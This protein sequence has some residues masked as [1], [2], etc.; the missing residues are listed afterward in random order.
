MKTIMM[1]AIAAATLTTACASETP[2]DTVSDKTYGAYMIV[3][4]ENYEAKD[5]G[6]YAASL[7]PIYAKYGGEYVAFSTS[8]DTLEGQ[9]NAQAII[10]S[11]WP[12]VDA[13]NEFWASP[14]YREAIKLRDG[15]GQFTVVVVPALAV[16]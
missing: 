5:L 16:K 15:I 2:K 9:E 10:I 11:G 8:Y 13:A 12:N 7:G 4:G 1:A 6:P 3:K 14:E